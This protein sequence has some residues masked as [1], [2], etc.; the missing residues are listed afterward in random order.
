MVYKFFLDQMDL[1][2]YLRK[3]NFF[4]DGRYTLQAKKEIDSFNI[5]DVGLVD[6]FSLL[7]K[8]LKNKKLLIDFKIFKIDFFLIRLKK[9]AKKNNIK[10]I[11]DKNNSIDLIWHDRPSEKKKNFFLLMK[12]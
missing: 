9:I 8:K 5:F 10:I 3:K 6:F 12:N 4:T 7:S 1:L 2:Y 11:H